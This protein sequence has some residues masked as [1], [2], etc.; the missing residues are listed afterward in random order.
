MNRIEDYAAV[1]DGIQPFPGVVPPGY[2][3]DFLGILTDA[4]FREMLEVDAAATGGRRVVTE[5]PKLAGGLGNSEDRIERVNWFSAAYS[6]TNRMLCTTARLG[7]SR[8]MTACSRCAIPIFNVHPVQS[9]ASED[10]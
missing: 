8:P 7:A 6:T 3:A 10:E 2:M 5:I 4:R 9:S 1:F